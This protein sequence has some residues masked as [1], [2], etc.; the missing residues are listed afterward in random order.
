MPPSL[1]SID[2]PL[3]LPQII[4]NPYSMLITFPQYLLPKELIRG[5]GTQ[6]EST[7]IQS[8]IYYSPIMQTSASCLSLLTAKGVFEYLS[9]Y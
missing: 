8:C 2:D 1:G 6:W 5:T 3:F 4:F 9:Y 7:G